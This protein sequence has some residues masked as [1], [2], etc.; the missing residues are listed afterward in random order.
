MEKLQ[1]YNH[2]GSE[3]LVYTDVYGYGDYTSV[4]I[5]YDNMLLYKSNK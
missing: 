2:D 3:M 4:D 5:N 1:T